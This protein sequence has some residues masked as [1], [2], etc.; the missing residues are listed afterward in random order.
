MIASASSHRERFLSG[1]DARG[2]WMVREDVARTFSPDLLA[3][4]L[5][6]SESR[7]LSPGSS[8]QVVAG[9]GRGGSSQ[10]L[11]G[12]DS[13]HVRRL[14]RGGLVARVNHATYLR[15]PGRLARPFEEIRV[16]E[17]LA[18]LPV[19][20]AAAAYVAP[21]SGLLYRAVL[22]TDTIPGATT[23]LELLQ[24]H[25][26]RAESAVRA[27]GRL[28]RDVLERGVAHADLHP[29]NVLV[30]GGGAVWMI[31]FDRARRVK[32]ADLNAQ[33]SRI[34]ARWARAIEK[35]G[36]EPRWAEMFTAEMEQ[37]SR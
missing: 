29:G 24:Q 9:S 28:A 26:A 7:E 36:F 19:P 3:A 2:R 30:D 22:I 16:L 10:L 20:R 32:A 17:D 13:Y 37:W 25:D 18:G 33:R 15:V 35:R 21:A 1:A 23:L 8:I 11:I 6:G 5:R 4:L 34:V 14:L 31:D 12:S 27:A